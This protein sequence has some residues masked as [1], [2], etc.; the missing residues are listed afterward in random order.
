MH[1]FAAKETPS[2]LIF[3]IACNTSGIG[4]YFSVRKEFSSA[5]A[6]M[7]EIAAVL[8]AVQTMRVTLTEQSG[9][10]PGDFN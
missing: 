4:I 5:E 2:Q 7:S 6:K 8:Q 1:L 10:D 3:K 9:Q